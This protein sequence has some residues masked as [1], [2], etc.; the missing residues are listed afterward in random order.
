[1][2]TLKKRLALLLSA[3]MLVSVL[4]TAAW[5]GETAAGTAVGGDL[6]SGVQASE[7]ML[8]TYMSLLP[9]DEDYLDLDLTHYLPG[10]L[11]AVPVQTIL[12]NTT[13]YSGASPITVG[14]GETIVWAAN[15]DDNFQFV[16][17]DDV[18]DLTPRS[19]YNDY[20]SLTLI[21]GDG[22]QLNASNQRYEI[23]VAIT[24]MREIFSFQ[25]KST[26]GTE[27]AIYDTY[28]SERSNGDVMQ[29]GA[30]PKA[31]Q[32][33][34]Q[35]YLTMDLQPELTGLS[36]VV[37]KGRYDSEAA[38]VAAGAEELTAQIWGASA[39]GYLADYSYQTGYK[40]MPEVTVVL[41]RDGQTVYTENFVLYMYEATMDL[42]WNGLYA[43]KDG[44]RTNIW[45][46]SY[47]DYDEYLH[48][49]I[50]L[51][52]GYP[53]NGDYYFGAELYNP[54]DDYITDNGIA[55]VQS[56]CV[57]YVASA[58]DMPAAGAAE[59]IKDQLFSDAGY[60]GGYLADYSDGVIFS[61]LDT[62]GFMHYMEVKTVGS[63][64]PSEPRPTS[65]DT[66]FRA[67]GAKESADGSNY[68]AY[69]MSYKDDSYY[70]NGY[71]TVFLLKTNDGSD[72]DNYPTGV[73][74]FMPVAD[75]EI[76][77]LFYTGNQVTMYAGEG[78]TSGTKQEN[79]ITSVSFTSGAPIQ[80]SAAAE[81]GSHLKNYWVTY[82]TLQP[83]P[84]LFVNATNY[85]GHYDEE[86]NL[87]VRTIYLDEAHNYRHDIFMANIGT[88]ELTGLTVTLSEDAQNIA[89]D[90]YW[91]VRDGSTQTLGAFDSASSADMGNIAKVRLVAPEGAQGEISGTL[92][93]SADGQEDVVIKLT[94][95]AGVPKITTTDIRDGVKYV[96]YSSVIQ[97]NNMDASDAIRFTL[98]SGELP[99]G[100]ELKPNGEIYGAPT[101][102]GEF[103]FTV[104]AAYNGEEEYSDTAEFTM[105]VLNNT[106][107]N[108]EGATDPGY[109]LDVRV[110]DRLTEFTDQVFESRG[111]LGEFQDFWLDGEKLVEGVDYIA[112]EGSTKIT[113]KAQTFQNAGGGTHTIAAEFRVNGTVNGELK[114]AAQ[115]YTAPG[116]GGGGSST[117][118]YTPSVSKSENGSVTL[119]TERAKKGDVVTVTVKPDTGYELDK[120]TVR[121]NKGNVL[122]LTKKSEN[123]YTFVMPSGTVDVKATFKAV[124]P[125][126]IPAQGQPFLD[127]AE[128]AWYVD[129]VKYA[130]ENGLMA[131]VS[132]TQFAPE[133]T[134]SRGM[135]VTI[136]YS[137]EGKPQVS[138][139]SFTDVASDAYYAD[140]TCWAA[141]NGIVSG[142]GD[143]IYGPNDPVTRE[144]LAII[145][146]N[147]AKQKGLDVSKRGDLSAF[148]DVSI[149]SAGAQDALSWANAMG[150]LAGKGDGILDPVGQATRAEA[151]AI[152]GQFHRLMEEMN[153]ENV[154]QD[155]NG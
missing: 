114:R 128:G 71:Q 124:E 141:Q 46:I 126:I 139:C 134:T 132:A 111:E 58:E 67:N 92:T 9:L 127:V 11:A 91:Q 30:D 101:E 21:V 66:Y 40:N 53:V 154:P 131:G 102:Y 49:E 7:E 51:D 95:V 113:I 87:P 19:D 155:V 104:K 76:V 142:Y 103:T 100:V 84:K 96:P 26:E 15:G 27:I 108:V 115:N 80:Y 62:D 8:P 97:T 86:D 138:G 150:L 78:T 106:N 47:S 33:G 38:A 31:W 89:L 121:D 73:Y 83:G 45:D 122:E 98:V 77:P 5:A 149:A 79:G 82:L 20:V 63:R 3:L 56:A 133:V 147:Y 24:P 136:L 137:L 152:L 13:N 109:E 23:D 112:E 135:V 120:L 42:S 17:A 129:A 107:E 130:Y 70:Y 148:T 43:E 151:S 41:K 81:S 119:S 146:M 25:A 2:R 1:M 99:R 29:M 44:G 4:P 48:L 123:V 105:T 125:E 18:I 110:P 153:Q 143:G 54:A 144:Q 74:R 116:G 28:L 90:E 14:A 34:Q 39:A 59:N 140:A 36:A 57:G 72:Q 37:Y 88:Q 69:T 60:D 6:S 93:I 61:V 55:Y 64:L 117:S 50:A 16:K 10:E 22:D 68:S 94:G 85:E 12:D 118:Y 145:M 52:S 75:D 35:A 65:S 32:A